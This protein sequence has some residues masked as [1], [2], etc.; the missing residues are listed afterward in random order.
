MNMHILN[1]TVG[2][3]VVCRCVSEHK[4]IHTATCSCSMSARLCDNRLM[5]MCGA[6]ARESVCVCS[7]IINHKRIARTAACTCRACVGKCPFGCLCTARYAERFE[8]IVE[9]S[10]WCLRP[11][12]VNITWHDSCAWSYICRIAR[13]VR[14]HIDIV[15][16]PTQLSCG[17]LVRKLHSQHNAHHTGTNTFQLKY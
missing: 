10:Q 8:W 1:G 5:D 15:V 6:R 9:P 16:V 13:I 3:V 2:H 7:H 11:I 14:P 12:D 17:H 4:H